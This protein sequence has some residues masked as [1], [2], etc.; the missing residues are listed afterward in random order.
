MILDKTFTLAI[1]SV[2][3]I[4]TSDPAKAFFLSLSAYKATTV[5]IGP[6]MKRPG[7]PN[8]NEITILKK[9]II[10]LLIRYIIEI[11]MFLT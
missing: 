1:T 4:F 5:A 8:I 7:R 2:A 3:L 10:K 9:D 6:S 11:F